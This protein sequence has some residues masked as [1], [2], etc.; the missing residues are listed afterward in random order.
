VSAGQVLNGERAEL[1]LY[2]LW[3]V[4]VACGHGR[5]DLVAGTEPIGARLLDGEC[6]WLQ[7]RPRCD[8]PLDLGQRGTRFLLASVATAQ[9]LS[10]AGNGAGVDCQLI[11]HDRL[12]AGAPSQLD[13]SDLWRQVAALSHL[14]WTL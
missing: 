7:V 10:R 5:P 14:R 4:L 3:N 13:A 6:R 12:G 11:A 8:L 2:R 1:A 9:L